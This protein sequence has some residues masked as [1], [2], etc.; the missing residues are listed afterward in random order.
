MKGAGDVGVV[1]IH[2]G[3]NWGY[4]VPPAHVRFAHRLIDGGIDI[5]HG[6]SSHHPRPFEVYRGKLV[7]YGSGDFLNDYEGISGYE[8]YRDDLVLMYFPVVEY[9]SS[10]LMTLTMRPMR[11]RT[12]KLH[13]TSTSE[14]EWLRQTADRTSA[15]FGSTVELGEDGD[16]VLRWAPTGR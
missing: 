14:T 5:V 3:S 6:H 1:S 9:G 13:R 10:R 15:E 4:D 12:M 7:L 8:H 16:L 2:W 11:I